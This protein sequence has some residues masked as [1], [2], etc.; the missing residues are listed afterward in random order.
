MLQKNKHRIVGKNTEIY[1]EQS[2]SQRVHLHCQFCKPDVL[3]TAK[4]MEKVEKNTAI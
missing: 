2:T 4:S 1:N 3:K